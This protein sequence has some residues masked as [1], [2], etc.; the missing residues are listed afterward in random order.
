VTYT[1]ASR[2]LEIGG[3]SVVI[4]VAPEPAVYWTLNRDREGTIWWIKAQGSLVTF[5]SFGDFYVGRR[6]SDPPRKS[7]P[8][9]VTDPIAGCKLCENVADSPDPAIEN[10]A[11]LLVRKGVAQLRLAIRRTC[12]YPQPEIA[13]SESPDLCLRG[14]EI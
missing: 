12:R 6:L 5:G 10:A 3:V 1:P 4:D 13:A 2:V 8:W 9:A 11:R 7:E 14:V